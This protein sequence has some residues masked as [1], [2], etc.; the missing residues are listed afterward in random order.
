MLTLSDGSRQLE[1]RHVME[2]LLGRRLTKNEAV[3]HK[4]GVR[5]DNRLENLEVLSVSHHP[6][7]HRHNGKIF[8][9]EERKCYDCGGQTE[10]DWYTVTS[11]EGQFRCK[12]C[13]KR[14]YRRKRREAGL[15]YS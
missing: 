10:G 2:T 11:I 14:L 5:D 15:S 6:Q 8:P 9:M 13:H 12:K 3:H 7:I 1:H 4:N